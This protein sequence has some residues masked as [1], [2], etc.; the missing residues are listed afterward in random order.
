RL[1]QEEES[2]TTTPPPEI[3]EVQPSVTGEAVAE[4]M[5]TTA[6]EAVTTAPVTTAV[7]TYIPE[8]TQFG[9]DMTVAHI[10]PAEALQNLDAMEDAAKQY[11]AE[12]YTSL[13]LPLKLENGMLQYASAVEQAVTCGASNESML[14]LREI[15]NAANRSHMQCTALFS[16]L[17]DQ[18]YS[19][20]FME[21]TYV[22]Q[23][24]AT[25]WFDNKPEEGGKPW[26]NPFDPAA[27][28]YLSALTEEIGKSGITDII[29]TNIVCPDFFQSDAELLGGH[30]LDAEQRRTALRSVANSIAETSPNAG[31]YLPLE[32]IISG[33]AEVFDAQQLSMKT[34]YI[35]LNPDAFTEAF[36]VGEQR[37]DPTAL[38]FWERIQLLAEA[39]QNASGGRNVIPCLS[40]E[41]L[42]ETQ[43]LTAIQALQQIGCKTVYI[44]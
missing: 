21:G 7:T 27:S 39:A 14:T 20:Y 44:L 19:N 11:A 41:A 30:I 13:I 42:N 25:R 35:G 12:G 33:K 9:T 23:D 1:Q 6:T 18:T 43:I 24:G 17:L 4:H 38:K 2:P 40:S 26:L 5:E 31:L 16:S 3:T 36:T 32:D 8:N 15:T 34:L 10:I 29:C 37:Y 28:A 22:F